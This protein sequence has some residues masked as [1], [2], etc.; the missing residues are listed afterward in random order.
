MTAKGRQKIVRSKPMEFKSSAG[1]TILVG[2]NNSQND[3]LTLKEADQ[4]GY[5]APHP[6][7]PTAPTSS[8]R[9]AGERRTSSPSPR[10][11]CW[12]PGSPRAGSRARCGGLHPG[13]VREKACRG[14]AGFVIYN[15]YNTMYVTPREE[16]VKELRV[17]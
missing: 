6:E 17:K 4:A 8:S 13:E 15:T 2:K 16:L 5:L 10:R 7:D 3:R 14:K 1:L 9:P 12:R 11:P